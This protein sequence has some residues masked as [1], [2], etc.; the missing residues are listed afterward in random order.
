MKLSF[1]SFFTFAIL[2]QIVL[3]E[4]LD[5]N[6]LE[7]CG[8]STCVS[9]CCPSGQFINITYCA[10]HYDE[11]DL[12]KPTF[13]DETKEP[14]SATPSK[15]KLLYRLPACE[16]FFLL[17]HMNPEDEFYLLEDGNLYVPL[18]KKTYT[19]RSYCIDK[20]GMN[21][22]ETEEVALLCFDDEGPTEEPSR[23]CDI[24]KEYV[25]PILLMVSCVF[26]I[27]TLFVY[28]CIPELRGKLH[29][30]CLLSL[31]SSL[32]AT[33]IL[34]TVIQL[35]VEGVSDPAC[36]T[37]AF[38]KQLTMLAS[39]FWLNVMCFDIWRSL[40]SMRPASETS[41]R[42]R[43]RF[44]LYSLY[45]WGSP[46]LI[47]SITMVMQTLDSSHV[48]IVRPNFL[49]AREMCWFEGRKSLW[50]Y[51]YMIILILVNMNICFFVMV[52]YILLKS[53]NNQQLQR[54][55]SQN[56]DRLWLC[57]K[58]FL[59]MGI[60]WITEV[61]SYQQGTCEAWIL[62]DSINALQGFIIFLVF[63][64][65]KSTR[66]MVGPRTDAF[67]SGLSLSSRSKKSDIANSLAQVTRR[68]SKIKTNFTSISSNKSK[69]SSTFFTSSSQS[70]TRNTQSSVISQS[71][72]SQSLTGTSAEG[73]RYPLNPMSV[74][75]ETDSSVEE[76][77]RATGADRAPSNEAL[78]NSPDAD[79]DC[80]SIPEDYDRSPESLTA[81]ESPMDALEKP[82]ALLNK[83]E[84]NLEPERKSTDSEEEPMVNGIDNA[85]GTGPDDTAASSAVEEDSTLLVSGAKP[86][87]TSEVSQTMQPEENSPL[88]VRNMAT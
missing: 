71:S 13:Y 9:K 75:R 14:L 8:R 72:E 47:A 86:G 61:I 17:P 55:R 44:L 88:L 23:A 56:R 15:L 6:E 60:V 66:Q 46:L 80:P 68:M 1:S 10:E 69:R 57:G 58:I 63:V 50:L 29:G 12:W 79:E 65:K 39:F 2:L 54:A 52:A 16:S 45:A 82:E 37:F 3:S 26:L 53:R 59:V 74:I 28:V 76:T 64:C 51:V 20:A 4:G 5:S 49:N 62:T 41:A 38:F 19:P 30:R 83:R 43:Q 84:T 42:S 34:M 48:N 25:Y 22:V 87:V 27:I 18:Y 11:S 73:P 35:A 31:V 67:R 40:K 85:Q 81:S 21:P 70:G 36:L 24:A 32:L 7:D 78:T 33:Y 77:V